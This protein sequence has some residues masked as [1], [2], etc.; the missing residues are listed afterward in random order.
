[1]LY[2]TVRSEI[3]DALICQTAD[4]SKN[5]I[6]VHRDRVEQERRLEKVYRKWASHGNVWSQASAKVD[7]F[8]ILDLHSVHIWWLDS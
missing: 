8:S 1:M 7:Y 4:H 3:V 2:S 6:A 5:Q